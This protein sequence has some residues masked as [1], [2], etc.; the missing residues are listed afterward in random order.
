[1]INFY[2]YYEGRLDNQQLYAE[3]LKYV[4]PMSEQYKD[5]VASI[6][7][8]IK[9]SPQDAYMYARLIKGRWIEAEPY[10]MRDPVYVFYYAIGV[11]RGRWLEAEPIIQT[12]DHLWESYSRTFKI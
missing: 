3:P 4:S 11:I 8:I 9:K 7:H 10:I 12:N 5:E 6:L 2:K 1:M